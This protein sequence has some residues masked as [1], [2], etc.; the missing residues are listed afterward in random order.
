MK[1]TARSFLISQFY[2]E[3]ESLLDNRKFQRSV[4]I[5]TYYYDELSRIF[6]ILILLSDVKMSIRY[7]ND[8][9]VRRINKIITFEAYA[10]L[11]TQVFIQ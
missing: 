9:K 1:K 2:D 8:V 11:H 3:S 7:R 4:F 10:K 5:K 6:F